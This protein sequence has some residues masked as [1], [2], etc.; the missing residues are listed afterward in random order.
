MGEFPGR[1]VVTARNFRLAEAQASARAKQTTRALWKP[2][3]PSPV[4][5]GHH[6]DRAGLTS[7]ERRTATLHGVIGAVGPKLDAQAE[8]LQVYGVKAF[9]EPAI[10][11]RQ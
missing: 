4:R 8:L 11:R 6:G 10:D 1:R 3:D 7:P 9:G 5:P 2:Q